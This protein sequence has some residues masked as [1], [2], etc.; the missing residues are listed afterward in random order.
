MELLARFLMSRRWQDSR[1]R[2][3]AAGMMLLVGSF[4]G[5]QPPR[6]E[7]LP[8]VIGIPLEPEPDIDGP[9]VSLPSDSGRVT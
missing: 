7:P 2:S 4:F 5:H 6:I 9:R 8:T 1:L 3:E